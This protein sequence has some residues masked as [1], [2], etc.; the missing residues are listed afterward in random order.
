MLLIEHD[1]DTVAQ[2]NWVIELGPGPGDRGGSVIF[3]GAPHL[4]AQ[5]E[6]PWGEAI[7][8]RIDLHESFNGAKKSASRKKSAAG[9]SSTVM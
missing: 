9:S 4:L 5:Q 3:E 6:T 2:S 1:A 7:R 8:E